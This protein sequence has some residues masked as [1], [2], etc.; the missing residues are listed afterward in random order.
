MERLKEGLAFLAIDLPDG[1][2][3][4]KF[5]AQINTLLNE[6]KLVDKEAVVRLQ[7]WRKGQRGYRSKMPGKG[8]YSI[9]AAPLT[10]SKATCRLAT[11]PVKRIPS[12][13]VPSRYKLSN[14]MNYILAA[15]QAAE[16]DADDALMETTDGNVSETTIANIF[17][18]RNK[19]VYTPSVD[20]DILPG[21][22]RDIV[23]QL[24]EEELAAE[25]KTGRF[26]MHAVKNA[27]S[28]WICNSVK[29]VQPVHSIDE[30]RFNTESS[31]IQ[32]L[33]RAFQ[34]FREAK[35]RGVDE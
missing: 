28:V 5:S 24:L 14:G 31:F 21:I 17:W 25:V 9:T 1:L 6:N 29:E 33:K 26:S 18:L 16:Q 8:S 3:K 30:T 22:T 13:A 20:C 19:T 23:L 15:N 10:N 12:S 27:D 2:T 34:Y 35:L 7:V 11:V 4:S 32:T